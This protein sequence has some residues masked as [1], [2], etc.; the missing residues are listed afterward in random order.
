MR[1]DVIVAGGRERRDLVGGGQV[2]GAA[3][4]DAS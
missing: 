2:G 4:S 1:R 3:Q